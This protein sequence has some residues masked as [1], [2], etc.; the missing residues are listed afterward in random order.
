MNY[1]SVSAATERSFGLRTG[2]GGP[3]GRVIRP[4]QRT[5][6]FQR[7][8]EIRTQRTVE[9]LAPTLS[10]GRCWAIA[11]SPGLDPWGTALADAE[12]HSGREEHRFAQPR[13]S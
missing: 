10:L 11:C 5:N 1:L 2:P 6:F 4:I 8:L 13:D 12:D 7:T 9:Y 3:T